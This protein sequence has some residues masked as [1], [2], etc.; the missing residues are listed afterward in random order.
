MRAC[1]AHES[2]TLW[3]TSATVDWIPCGANVSFRT[4]ICLEVARARQS[5]G[6]L[7]ISLSFSLSLCVCVY[8]ICQTRAV[9]GP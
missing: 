1:V 5:C 3:D 6:V 4:L 7:N 9:P 2:L 8:G